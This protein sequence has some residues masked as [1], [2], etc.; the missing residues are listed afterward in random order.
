MI[1]LLVRVWAEDEDEVLGKRRG[2]KAIKELLDG[3][4]Y[5]LLVFLVVHTLGPNSPFSPSTTK[6]S[7]I[8]FVL[9][10]HTFWIIWSFSSGGV[11]NVQHIF[12]ELK[13]ASTSNLA[14]EKKDTQFRQQTTWPKTLQRNH[15]KQIVVYLINNKNC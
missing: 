8:S 5:N 10:S 15:N 13:G 2:N 4:I 7:F 14:S 3:I 6:I 9:T 1:G 11:S 12:L